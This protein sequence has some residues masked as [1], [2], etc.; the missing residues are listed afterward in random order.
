MHFLINF[1]YYICTNF[2]IAPQ[3][4][5]LLGAKK[6]TLNLPLP[7]VLFGNEDEVV[8]IYFNNYYLIEEFWKPN[9]AQLS[10]KKIINLTEI[11]NISAIPRLSTIILL[12][13][14]ELTF[15]LWITLLIIFQKSLMS[16]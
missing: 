15:L 9:L 4:L 12:G 5:S 1:S 8:L 2:I 14:G 7:M 13:K 6:S 11:N 10:A 3:L 16:F